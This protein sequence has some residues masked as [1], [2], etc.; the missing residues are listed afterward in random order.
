MTDL[1]RRTMLATG[2]LALA[3]AA[4]Q[5]APVHAEAAPKAMFPVAAVTIPIVGASEVFQVRR[6]Y[7]IGRNYAAHAIERG[8]DPTREPPFFFQKPTDAIQNVAIGTVADHPYPSLTKN[9]HHEVE[10]VA[11][12]KSGGTNIPADKALDHVYGYALGLDMTRRDLQN[13]MAAE[14]KPWE[15]GKSFDHAAVLGPIHPADKTGHFTQGAI[16]LA[17]NGTV[18]QSSD[19]KNM[20][21]SVAEQIAKL[22]E[23]FELKAGDIIYSG[24]PEN[25]GPVVKGDVLLCKLEGLPDMSI[26]IV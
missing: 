25:V 5:S 17:I 2:A 10:L 7:C 8:S 1:D 6:I 23:A 18:R 9:Y 11:A 15:I 24:T 20:I 12:L 16:S 22:S 13:G 4:A 14:K 26:K 19:L 21:W 3:G